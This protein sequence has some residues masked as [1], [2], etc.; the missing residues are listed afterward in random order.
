[1]GLFS[2]NPRDT[3]KKEDPISAGSF[4]YGGKKYRVNRKQ[5]LIPAEGLGLL[6]ATDICASEEAQKYLIE[7]GCVGSILSED[8]D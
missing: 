1:M 2:R 6:T 5:V 3:S 4:K 7:N 8:I